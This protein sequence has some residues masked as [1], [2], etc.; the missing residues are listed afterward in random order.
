[1]S[2]DGLVIG[3]VFS[4]FGLGL[5]VA[6]IRR[7]FTGVSL[8]RSA[9]L[10]LREIPQS[11]G[12]IEFD[13]QVAAPAET[14]AFEA[15]FSGEEAVICQIWVEK[16]SR[17]PADDGEE[18]V[19]VTLDR[20]HSVEQT[21]KRWGLAD[22]G[23]IRQSLAVTD[24]GARVVVDPTDADL[25]LAGHMGEIELGTEE[26]EA[27]SEEVRDRL[28]ALDG[29]DPEFD[30]AVE[31]WDD[32]ESAVK[33]REE[34]LE[35]G[36]AVHVTGATVESTPEEWGS[37]IEATVADSGADRFLISRGTESAVIRRNLIQFV[38]G[39]IVGGISLAIGGRALYL[40]VLA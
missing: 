11:E 26:G 9:A 37:G 12:A 14:G 2:I 3:V 34:R 18:G 30:T 15:P 28:A 32:E 29:V 7:L 23:E 33:Y 27:L 24:G 35:P 6:G 40:A 13:G 22:T 1:M 21:E 5:S 38:T 4:L 31:T 39:T 36:E 10:P 16:M 19:D 8:Y 17:V 25:D 20:E